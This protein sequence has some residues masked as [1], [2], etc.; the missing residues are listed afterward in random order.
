ME[1]LL[2]ARIDRLSYKGSPEVVL[3]NVCLD[4]YPGEFIHLRGPN[5]SGKSALCR[6]LAGIIP[7]FES[8]SLE[9]DVSFAAATS[10]ICGYLNWQEKSGS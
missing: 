4:F 10:L 5:G 8:A 9:G 2:T 3:R 7:L 1:Q 6:C